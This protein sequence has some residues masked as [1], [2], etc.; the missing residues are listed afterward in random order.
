MFAKK[1]LLI[2]TVALI[3]VGGSAFAAVNPD[4]NRDAK[5]DWIDFCV[6]VGVA[7]FDPPLP[8][9]NA[10]V[11]E[12]GVIDEK[13]LV[14]IINEPGFDFEKEL[15]AHKKEVDYFFLE[16]RFIGDVNNNGEVDIA[17]LSQISINFGKIPPGPEDLD[18]NGIVDI[19]DIDSGG[20]FF[21]RVYFI[22][23]EKTSTPNMVSLTKEEAM[24]FLMFL[25]PKSVSP[26]DKLASKWGA[27]KND[28]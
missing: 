18:G 22:L 19:S 16:K 3:M 21:L 8:A 1:F 28:R 14:I 10:D 20:A 27:M 6:V 26:R 13:D 23:L 24:G 12:D 25:S 15:L 17:D 9:A 4:V 2:I 11:N 5:V 7:I